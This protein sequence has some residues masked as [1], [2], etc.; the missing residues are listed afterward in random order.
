MVL[1]FP[2]VVPYTI[3]SQ[4][5]LL[6]IGCR[7]AAYGSVALQFYVHCRQSWR[8]CRTTAARHFHFLDLPGRNNRTSVLTLTLLQPC[9]HLGH[10]DVLSC[11]Y[12][13]SLSCSSLKCALWNRQ[14]LLLD[15]PAAERQR[16]IRGK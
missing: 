14:G 10:G 15:G 16:S 3:Q 8:W 7:M 9:C 12:S 2:V 1:I 13:F 11:P 6:T 4:S 5:S